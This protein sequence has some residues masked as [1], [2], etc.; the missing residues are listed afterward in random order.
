MAETLGII[1]GRGRLPIVIAEGMRASGHRICGVGLDGF[2]DPGFAELCDEFKVAGILQIG[3]WIRHCKRHGA[4]RAV[5]AGTVEKVQLHDPWRLLRN[6]P[7]WRTIDIWYRRARHDKRSSVLLRTLADELTRSGVELIDSTSHIPDHLALEGVMTRNAPSHPEDIVFGW[8]ILE[9]SVEWEIGQAITVRERDVIGV[10][11]IEGT[12]RLIER[13]GGLC[14]RGGW[15]LLKTASRDHDMRA[16]VPT[17]GLQTIEMLA[18][19]GANCLAVGA[20]RTILLER[21]KVIEAAEAAG[22]ALVGI[23]DSGPEAAL[24]LRAGTHGG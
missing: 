9:Q 5:I 22:I 10:E 3:R 23:G 24:S 8:S 12:D 17:I 21:P 19:H 1:A 2:H 20:G 7:D 14:R 16:D 6:I 15:T 11:A 13:S 4:R 18:K